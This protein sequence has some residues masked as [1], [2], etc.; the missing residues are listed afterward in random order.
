M[1]PSHFVILSK[2]NLLQISSGL[3]VILG[4]F[5]FT[6][7]DVLEFSIIDSTEFGVLEFSGFVRILFSSVLARLEFAVLVNFVFRLGLKLT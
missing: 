6:N 2:G 7:F 5:G 1:T 3:E 4:Y